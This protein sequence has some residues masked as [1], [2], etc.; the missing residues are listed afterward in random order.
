[1]R[2]LEKWA[3]SESSTP[4]MSAS[5][6]SSSWPASACAGQNGLEAAGLRRGRPAHI[7]RMHHR[8]QAREAAIVLQ[9]EARQQYLE[10]HPLAHVRE[11]RTVEVEPQCIGWAVGRGVQ[12]QKARMR[13][14]KS[15]GSARRSPRG[16]PRDGGAWPRLVPG[17]ACDHA[18]QCCPLLAAA[19]RVTAWLR[20][21]WRNR[22]TGRRR[23]STSHR[24]R[25]RF[26]G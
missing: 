5:S 4:P 7:E 26:C 24:E 25:S 14:D 6:A 17:T 3:W 16:P 20:G 9:A 13:V 8:A 12:P 2:L 23:G 15:A 10:R 1:L 22:A 18:E 19:H 21:R 11:G